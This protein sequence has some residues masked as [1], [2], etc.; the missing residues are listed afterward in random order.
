M[1][2]KFNTRN[3]FEYT[4]L[5]EE[6]CKKRGILGRLK[7]Q[8][9]DTNSPTRNGRF[10]SK[11]LWEKVFNSP[12]M[13]EKIEN[14]VCYGELGHPEDRTEI[15]IEKIAVCLAEQPKIGDDGKIYGVFDILDTPNGR[16][17]K[18]LCDYGTTVGVSSRGTG[19]VFLDDDGNEFVDSDTYDCECW[20][21][22]LLPAVKTARMQYVTESLDKEKVSLKQA[23]NESLNESSVEDRRVMEKTL[24]ELN[25]DYQPEQLGDNI[26]DENVEEEKTTCTEEATDSGVSE[27]VK[28]LQEALKSKAELEAK[29][30]DIQ[31][32]LAVSDT[33]VTKLEE[34]LNRYKS[35]SIKLSES[36]RQTKTQLEQIQR[37]TEAL[38]K[39][40][41]KI[42][43]QRNQ[44]KKL[45]ES[46]NK[47]DETKTSLNESLNESKAVI[48]KLT[49]QVNEFSK[50]ENS[51]KEEI[52]DLNESLELAR[53]NSE[54]KVKELTKKLQESKTT[55]N[56][57]KR[58]AYNTVNKYIDFRA[59][60]LGISS[61]EI[62]NRLSESYTLEDVDNV[63]EELQKRS[64]NMSK[65]PFNISK[66][67]KIKVTESKEPLTSINND[68][69]VDDN[70]LK[71]ANLK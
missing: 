67:T 65:L 18:T 34:E 22:V 49:E 45:V 66:D 39:A 59:T 42:D 15:D 1:L 50:V 30:L 13:K 35:L 46:S 53:T 2:E 61:N 5:T 56:S 58:I 48:K 43:Y 68:D 12:I 63:C 51:Y 54:N 37:L 19:D 40:N 29:I 20:D 69:D 7:G 24:Q 64:I 44:I 32:E 62:K 36:A 28:N 31:N 3:A 41:Q 47:E 33:K 52:N 27:L 38:E 4:K 25:I 14:R 23:L 57:Y 9:A 71:L 6:E 70:L 60:M 21:I 16:I 55:V 8:I 10:Y 11:E 26:E 17:L